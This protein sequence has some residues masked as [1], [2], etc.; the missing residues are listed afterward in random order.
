VCSGGRL[1]AGGAASCWPTS[2]PPR[3]CCRWDADTCAAAGGRRGR[4]VLRSVRGSPPAACRLRGTP[5][6]AGRRNRSRCR[7]LR[8]GRGPPLTGSGPRR[9]PQSARRAGWPG[10]AGRTPV[11]SVPLSDR[12]L[13]SVL[14]KYF[15]TEPM[16]FARRSPNSKRI[17]LS[18]EGT[19]HLQ[20][21]QQRRCRRRG[22]R[23]RSPNR[24]KAWGNEG[25][26]RTWL[27]TSG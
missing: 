1:P 6:A 4:R 25:L 7:R 19:L 13:H 23:D 15:G 14:Q 10:P 20:W 22:K 12:G 2:M 9:A 11:H 8:V 3:S 18:D 17:L 21:R 27:A 26:R 5:P 24:E 16:H